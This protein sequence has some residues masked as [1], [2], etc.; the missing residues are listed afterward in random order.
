MYIPGNVRLHCLK[1]REVSGRIRSQSLKDQIILAQLSIV[2]QNCYEKHRRLGTG[3]H[4]LKCITLDKRIVCIICDHISYIARENI[5]FQ[6]VQL[7]P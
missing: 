5:S 7:S 6:V 2:P 1:G 3:K 4:I